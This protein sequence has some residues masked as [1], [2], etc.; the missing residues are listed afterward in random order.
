MKYILIILI[1]ITLNKCDKAEKGI[2]ACVQK[3][4]EQIKKEPVWNP[5]AEVNEYT[6]KGETSFFIQ[7]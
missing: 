5:P 2:T 1:I 7:Q 4:I 6:Y 3:K